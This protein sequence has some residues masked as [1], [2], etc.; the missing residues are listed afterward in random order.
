MHLE[1]IPSFHRQLCTLLHAENVFRALAESLTF[2]AGSETDNLG[3]ASAAVKKLSIILM[4]STELSDLR[5]KLK[6]GSTRVSF[7]RVK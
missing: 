1:I 3:F 5:N 4:T 2:T 6:N 7:L